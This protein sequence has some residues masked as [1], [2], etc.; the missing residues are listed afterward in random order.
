M[1]ENSVFV[2]HFHGLYGRLITGNNIENSMLNQTNNKI[3]GLL[4]IYNI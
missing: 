2:E 3:V 4:S 1:L